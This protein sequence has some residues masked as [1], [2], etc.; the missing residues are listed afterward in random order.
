MLAARMVLAASLVSAMCPAWAGSLA[1][2]LREALASAR[3]GDRL[4]VVVLMEEFP[5]RQQTARRGPRHE[6]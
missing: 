4:P 1:P 6:P 5:E 2:D 3:P